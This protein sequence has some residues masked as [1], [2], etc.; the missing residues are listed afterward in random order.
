MNRRVRLAVC[1]TA[2]A[3]AGTAAG[4]AGCRGMNMGD[5]QALKGF[6][7][8]V[9]DLRDA[10]RDIS[11]MEEFEYGK[12]ACAQIFAGG[13]RP[14]HNDALTRYVTAVGSTL[15]MVSERPDPYDGYRFTVVDSDEMNAFAAPGGFIVVTKGCLKQCQNE[16]QLAAVLAH[17]IA[18]IERN[19]PID[20]LRKAREQAAFQKVVEGAAST[21]AIGGR[22]PMAGQLG[23]I[24]G[25]LGTLVQKGYSRDT[26][27]DA[28]LRAVDLL[29]QAGYNP[30]E[31]VRFFQSMGQQKS[32]VL[33]RLLATHYDPGDRALKVAERI[34]EYEAAGW[35]FDNPPAPR[36]VRD[37][38]FRASVR[39]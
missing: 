23:T 3:A 30:N 15:A 31:M 36:A 29:V 25:A 34:R 28:D 26:E 10:R 2:V 22:V 9:R 11:P 12:A 18:H 37:Q 24:S 27:E 19:H 7:G 38:R 14:M 8:G 1:L 16:D 32:G 17:E 39:L 21:S 35:Q 13:A 20:G 6:A 5:L 33:G 4:I